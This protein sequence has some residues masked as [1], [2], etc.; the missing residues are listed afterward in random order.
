[1][2]RLSTTSRLC[3]SS[4]NEPQMIALSSIDM[5]LCHPRARLYAILEQ[6]ILDSRFS[7]STT[8]SYFQLSMTCNA[9]AHRSQYRRERMPCIPSFSGGSDTVHVTNVSSMKT[10]AVLRS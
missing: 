4:S 6:G 7:A 9:S 3:H 10:E 2:Q 8:E 5:H 1:M